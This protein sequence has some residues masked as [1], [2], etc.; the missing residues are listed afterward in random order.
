MKVA[1]QAAAAVRHLIALSGGRNINNV[2]SHH[3][4]QWAL[5]YSVDIL[6]IN[7]QDLFLHLHGCAKCTAL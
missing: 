5:T 7:R 6:M 4:H 1:Q 3:T 2:I